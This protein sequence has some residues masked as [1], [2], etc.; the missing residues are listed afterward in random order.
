MLSGLPRGPWAIL[1]GP[2]GGWSESE[3]KRLAA[4]D[5]VT[6]VALGLRWFPPGPIF[7]GGG[8]GAPPPLGARPGR[9]PDGRQAAGPG[10]YGPGR[11]S[12]L[13]PQASRSQRSPASVELRGV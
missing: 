9:L 13:P 11:L 8:G 2:E 1:I 12:L 4:M 3:R 5:C 6:P 7:R 10:V